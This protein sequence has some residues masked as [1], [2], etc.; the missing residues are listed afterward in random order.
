M[1]L[2]RHEFG[3][4]TRVYPIR[5]VMPTKVYTFTPVTGDGSDQPRRPSPLSGPGICAVAPTRTEALALVHE[6]EEV[7]IEELL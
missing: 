4:L 7:A 3:K 6:N 1:Y 2:A 5:A